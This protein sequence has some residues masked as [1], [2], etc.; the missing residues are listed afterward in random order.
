MPPSF[1]TILPIVTAVTGVVLLG[2]GVVLGSR[3]ALQRAR[4]EPEKRKVGDPV[5]APPAAAARA[6]AAALEAPSSVRALAAQELPGGLRLGT[7]GVKAFAYGTA[8]CLGGGAAAAL[9]AAWA[10]DVRDL[11]GFA[12][13]MHELMPGVRQR[14]ER[15]LEPVLGGVAQGG[16]AVA[17]AADG[18]V[19]SAVRAYVPRVE[20]AGEEAELAGLNS[21]E[22]AAVREFYAWIGEDG[23]SSA[24]GGGSGGS[25]SGGSGSGG[26]GSGSGAGRAGEGGAA[27]PAPAA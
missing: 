1:N 10:L 25:G 14:M 27:G 4:E 15:G 26:S 13:R 22:R 5:R 20:G 17:R 16:R 23:S 21:R 6:A 11:Q 7:L 2:G 8:L 24:V 18:S 19:G 3:S 12:Q 9:L